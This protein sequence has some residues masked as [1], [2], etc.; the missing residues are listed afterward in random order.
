MSYPAAN[1]EERDGGFALDERSLT[2]SG[3]GGG[4]VDMDGIVGNVC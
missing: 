3:G 1:A 2:W 4:S